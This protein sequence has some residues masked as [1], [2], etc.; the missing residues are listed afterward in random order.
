MTNAR[1][2]IALATL[3]AASFGASAAHAA[4]VQAG[5]LIQN[6]ASASYGSGTSQTTVNS[7]TVSI[8]VDELLDVT[9]NSLDA[10]SIA[11]ADR[12][13]LS[14]R[15]VNTGN[16]PEAFSIQASPGVS[17]NAF[18]AVV[19]QIVVDANDNGTYEPG[20]DTVIANGATTPVLAADASRSI[21]VI[22]SAPSGA[23]DATTSQVRVTA[24][25]ATGAGT[26]GTSFSGQ[27]QGGGDAVVGATTARA[28][29]LGS[30]VVSS[31][32]VTLTKSYV[33]LDPFGGAR[34][35]PGAV[36]TFTIAAAASGSGSVSNLHVRDVIPSG[37]SYIPS[38]LQLEGS[39]LSDAA[40]SDAGTASSSGID[41]AIDTLAGGTSRSVTFKTRIN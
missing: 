13:V 32:N 4:G 28:N 14:Y 7:N 36:V 23:G 30:L 31:A 40:D 15:L 16:G 18:D 39:S 20:V 33:V 19:E 38:S 26:P 17:G 2:T 3:A 22:V 24:E 11:L 21:F 6:T 34:P 27:G 12:A 41:V 1:N 8:R 9:V 29:A 25:A 5:T 35:V 10:G 37:T